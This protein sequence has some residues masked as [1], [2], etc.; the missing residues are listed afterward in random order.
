VL[1]QLSVRLNEG[2]T[3]TGHGPVTARRVHV[4]GVVLE[5]NALLTPTCLGNCTTKWCVRLTCT[6]HTAARACL[7]SHLPSVPP[8][9][10][11]RSS[12]AGTLHASSMLRSRSAYAPGRRTQS[13]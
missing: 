10:V 5:V 12:D 8:C 7:L 6:C 11:T 13:T 2:C 1:W 9:T 4:N 3:G